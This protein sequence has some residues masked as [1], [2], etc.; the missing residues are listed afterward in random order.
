MSVSSET[1]GRRRRMFM[2][3]IGPSAAAVFPSAPISI[4]A[5]DVEYRY[6]QD[7][8]LLY[9]TGF[10]EPEAVCL[11]LPE[12]PKEEF[13]MF[14]R[15][16]DPERETWTGRRAG[17][18]GAIEV[19]GAQ[20]AYPIDKLDEKIGEYVSERERLYF[21]FGRDGAFNQRVQGWMRQWQQL[22]PRSG[23]GPNALLDPSEIVHEMRLF[24]DEEELACLRQAIAIAAD[25]H[26]AA[27]RTARDGV[28]EY[29]VEAV[30]DY[31]F[32]R[33]GGSGPA[34][35]SIVAAGA[36][37]T[38]LH[39]T[40]N[41]QPMRAGELLLID[42]GA[43]YESYCADITRTFPVGRH[44]NEAQR[45]VYDVVLAAQLAA[46]DMVRPGARIEDPHRRAVEVL[47]DGLLALQLLAGNR[48]EIITKELYRSLYMHRTSHWLGMDVHDVGQY[49]M[50]G[51][52]RVLEP[53]M[54]LTVEPG[55][56]IGSER[57]DVAAC[58]LGIGVRI[59]DD[60]L[61]TPTG[62]EVLSAA[63]PKQPAELEALRVGA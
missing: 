30:L 61:V 43:E 63:V 46:I 44:F 24:K 54:V 28:R 34:Y 60:V 57:T 1:L 45:A 12:H 53:G 59:E 14:V 62:H 26:H 38:I 29:E 42:A 58:Y 50:E 47:V 25:G 27:M 15:P 18:E 51:R 19:Y 40:N 20:A 55:I 22:R 23:S 3:R 11:L 31:T 52:S 4:R 21:A 6:R 17:V 32:R 33:A 7:N 9:L 8:D 39:Y 41:D 13:V 37:A 36:N 35:P 10:S 5:N 49:K 2:D 16:R 56:Y 48:E